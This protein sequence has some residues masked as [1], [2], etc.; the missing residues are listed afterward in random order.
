MALRR[1]WK[2]GAWILGRNISGPSGE[3]A[4]RHLEGWWGDE[5]PY[6]VHVRADAQARKTLAMAGGTTFH[7]VTG[8][9]LEAL[10]LAKEA[11]GAR[12]VRIGGGAATIRQYVREGLIDELHLGIA[13]VLLGAGEPLLSGLPELAAKYICVEQTSSEGGSRP[14]SAS[15]VKRR[16]L[17][18]RGFRRSDYHRRQRRRR[19]RFRRAASASAARAGAATPCAVPTA[20]PK[21][22]GSGA[23]D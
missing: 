16:A 4:G 19:L 14:D 8:G 20:R 17:T 3:R 5:P 1:R 21:C 2:L 15:A 10:R 6:T 13:P 18:Q 23:A 9:I 7:F 11:A 12:D 22:R